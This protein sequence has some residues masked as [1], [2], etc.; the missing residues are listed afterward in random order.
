MIVL[1]RDNVLVLVHQ[2]EHAAMA[3]AIAQAWRPPTMLPADIWER[4]LDAVRCHDDGWLAAEKRPTLADDRRPFDFKQIPSD[5]HITIWRRSVDLA[6][7]RDAYTCLLV[8][9]HA[10]HLYTTTSVGNDDNPAAAQG[11]INELAVRIVR[12]TEPLELGDAQEQAAISPRCVN[13]AR[14]LLTMFDWLSLSLL[15]ALPMPENTEPLAFGE[16][17]ARLTITP[18]SDGATLSPWPFLTES[19]RVE[20]PATLVA[21]RAY[22]SSTA[23]LE[24]MRHSRPQTLAFTLRPA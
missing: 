1:K 20:C 3:A 22:D 2:P 19:V 16:G 5:Q 17:E 6:S 15:G 21:D 8:A 18:T 11:F 12:C 14:R 24:S 23:L 13:A 7:Q 10:R 4:F 9:H